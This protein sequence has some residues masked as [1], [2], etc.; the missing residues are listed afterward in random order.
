MHV[1]HCLYAILNI[2]MVYDK[3]V[4]TGISRWSRKLSHG[5]NFIFAAY[6]SIS[7]GFNTPS[8]RRV[9][10]QTI[11]WTS[12]NEQCNEEF[13]WFAW[14]FTIFP[15]F[16]YDGACARTVWKGT[17][18]TYLVWKKRPPLRRRYFQIIFVIEKFL[19]WWKFPWSLFLRVQST[20][21]QNFN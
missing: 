16:R 4:S 21:T 19:F 8:L 10:A 5:S 9:C 11:K 14:Q 18:L 1:F 20:I 3:H 7:T 2:T 13:S 15:D 17:H 6:L 12:I